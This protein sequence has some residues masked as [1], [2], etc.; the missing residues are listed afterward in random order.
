MDMQ[1]SYIREPVDVLGRL[2]PVPPTK[3][4]DYEV[5]INGEVC[6][7]ELRDIILFGLSYMS[8]LSNKTFAQAVDEYLSSKVGNL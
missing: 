6:P 5:K 2:D 8:V 7:P 3:L 1:I 4:D